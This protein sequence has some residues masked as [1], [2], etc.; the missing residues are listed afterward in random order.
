MKNDQDLLSHQKK[1]SDEAG[2]AL[3]ECNIRIEKMVDNEIA[4][5]TKQSELEREIKLLDQKRVESKSPEHRLLN[6]YNNPGPTER[7]V[8]GRKRRS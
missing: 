5:I 3:I 7:R 6:N 4:H 8:N 1:K 2:S